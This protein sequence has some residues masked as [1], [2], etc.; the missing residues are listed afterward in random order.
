MKILFIFLFLVQNL[1]A[2]SVKVGFIDLYGN[3]K[4][5]SSLVYQALPFKEGDSIDHQSFKPEEIEAKLLQI[6]GVKYASINPLCCDPNNNLIIYAGI[7]END[8]VILKHRNAPKGNARLPKKMTDDY[9]QFMEVLDTAIKS[10][11]GGEDDSKGYA[12]IKYPPARVFQNK[13]VQYAS[14]D[15]NTLKNVLRT[16]RDAEQRAVAAQIIAYSSQKSVVV[17]N[18]LYA[19]DDPDEGVRNNATRALS[20]L[21]GFGY[22]HP[23]LKITIPSA[24]FIKML[25]SIFW[26]DRNKGTNVLMQLTQ[27]RNARLL[28]EI[29][30]QA[31]SSLIEM[32]RW[33]DR[34]HAYAS[35]VILA[36]MAGVEEKLLIT[37]NYS[38]D[39]DKEV[40]MMIDK[41]SKQ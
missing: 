38:G 23:S 41:I 15:L 30:R 32:A 27:N 2:Q 5:P 25:N 18:L 37:K 35:F 7:G 13:F 4:T 16:S 24:P 20:I 26:K 3:R 6:P 31:Y 36:R 29:K 40:D 9:N 28:R 10:G 22:S 1:F 39:F 8:S 14:T 34:G 19:V 12:L 21:A 33:R 17:E 11:Q